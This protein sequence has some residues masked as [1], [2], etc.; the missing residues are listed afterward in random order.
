MYNMKNKYVWMIGDFIKKSM[1]KSSELMWRKERYV[2][3]QEQE[4]ML[5]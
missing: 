3:L 2:V 1:G 5:S 4:Y